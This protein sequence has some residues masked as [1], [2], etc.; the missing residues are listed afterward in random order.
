MSEAL[1]RIHRDAER[2]HTPSNALQGGFLRVLLLICPFVSQSTEKA[3]DQRTIDPEDVLKELPFSCNSLN[4][5]H[6]PQSIPEG[7]LWVVCSFGLS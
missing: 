7:G 3:L 6:N 4:L 5:L 1:L 2:P